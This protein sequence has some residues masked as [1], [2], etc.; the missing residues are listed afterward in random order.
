MIRAAPWMVLLLASAASEARPDAP[1][2][3][4]DGA[5]L[6]RISL[7]GDAE[8]AY[9]Y[10]RDRCDDLDV[11]DAPLR[12]FRDAGGKVVAFA[13]D[14]TN[15][16]L[17]GDTLGDLKRQCRSAYEGR[18]DP[19]PEAFD[20][21]TWIAAT[22]TDD[23]RNVVALGHNEYQAQQFPGKC[24]FGTYK[25]CWYNAVVLL[26]SGDG[27]RTFHRADG[28]AAEP[29][30]AAPAPADRYQGHPAGYFNPTNLVRFNG[31]HFAIVSQLGLGAPE[32]DGS[33]L[34]KASRPARLRSWKLLLSGRDSIAAAGNPYGG[35]PEHP[36]CVP[37]RSLQGIVGSIGRIAGTGWFVAFVLDAAGSGTLQAFYSRDLVAWSAPQA[38]ASMAS[39]WSPQCPAGKRYLYPSVVDDSTPSRNFDQLGADPWL[40]VVQGDCALSTA[41]DLVRFRLHIE[42]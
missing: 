25:E 8:V 42:P 24:R 38:V 7:V 35:K 15:R 26:R 21:R 23:G 2:A 11:P 32:S 14:Y 41:R 16:P 37:L 34:L 33:C 17:V 27:G 6:P 39:F 30:L 12:A 28:P 5:R 4:A 18:H 13:S 20:D 36:L 40:F 1:V 22:W 10:D 9:R 19:R 29:V 31:S 3:G